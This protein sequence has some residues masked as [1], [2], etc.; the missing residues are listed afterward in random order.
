MKVVLLAVTISLL[1]GCASSSSTRTV[2]RDKPSP[3]WEWLNTGVCPGLRPED[4]Q[5]CKGQGWDQIPNQ[6]FEA[7]IRRNRGEN[8]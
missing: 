8:W 7:Q 2:Y 3:K 6:E 4:P 1:A 5:F